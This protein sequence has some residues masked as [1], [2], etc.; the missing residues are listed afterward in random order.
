MDD[1]RADGPSSCSIDFDVFYEQ[2]FGRIVHVTRPLAGDDAE[3]IAQEAF[4]I[5]FIRWFEV[6]NFDAPYAWVQVV[7]RRLAMRRS[8]RDQARP[9][10]ERWAHTRNDPTICELALDLAIALA[11]LPDRHA[12]AF[13][14]HHLDDLPISTVAAEL[15]CS[16]GAAKVL[17]HRGR[18]RLAEHVGGYSGRWV[19]TATWSTD[20]IVQHLRS[21]GSAAH[22]DIIVEQHLANR[23]GRWQLMIADGRYLLSRDDGLT[24]DH[25]DFVIG[26]GH[27]LELT[28]HS[29]CG[30]VVFRAPVDGNVFSAVQVS[31]T[32]PPTDGVPD[33]IWM[34]LLLETSPFEWAGPAH[35]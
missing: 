10:F 25:G 20:A 12:T 13:E 27:R 22:I 26:R 1:A 15:E 5:A 16:Q 19:S 7:A 9:A 21:T 18:R 8:S 14:R 3:D 30:A 17:V 2:G 29:T 4:A 34:N 33:H 6:R 11:S 31:N 28:P 35:R 24:L 32:T 23:G